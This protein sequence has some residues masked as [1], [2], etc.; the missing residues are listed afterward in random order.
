MYKVS[1]ITVVILILCIFIDF[2]FLNFIENKNISTRLTILLSLFSG[3]YIAFKLNK[4]N[5][6]KNFFKKRKENLIRVKIKFYTFLSIWLISIFFSVFMSCY[7]N[8]NLYYYY[9][10]DS[11]IF[12]PF[13]LF[14]FYF[15]V[16]YMDSRQ[17]D[18]DDEYANFFLDIKKKRFSWD[19]YRLFLLNT[20]VKV[21]YIPFMYGAA[22]LAVSQVLTYGDI[23]FNILKFINFL[24]LIGVCFDVCIGLGG[25]IFSSKFFATETISVDGSW[26]G[27]LVCLICYPPLVILSKIFLVQTDSY[28]WSHWLKPDETLY[29]IWATLICLT[30]TCYWLATVSFG[31]K[32]SNLSWRG[33]VD[34]GLYR[35]VKHPAYLSKNIY[36]WL[37]TIPLF[38]VVGIDMLRNV[39][40]LSI[41]SL[42]YYLRAKTEEKHLMQFDEYIQYCRWI[43]Q[44]GFYAKIK[45]IFK[46]S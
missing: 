40:A 18:P 1:L 28:I 12:S 6:K 43:D 5:I 39:L 33:L 27:W 10:Y 35:Y 42:I 30:W 34:T 21:F 3:L 36:W 37:H 11:L 4:K 44:N 19:S 29:W 26:Q 8:Q 38:G 7:L 13:I 14:I 22:F 31:F 20:A 23:F 45:K 25:Y 46:I 15:W 32:F 24:F 41:I 17:E 2:T 16:F 9:Y